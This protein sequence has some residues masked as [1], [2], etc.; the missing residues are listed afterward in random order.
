MYWRVLRL[1]RVRPNGWQRLLLVEGS[2]ASGVVLA[3]ADASSA[4]AIVVLPVTVAAVVKAHDVLAGIL[5]PGAARPGGQTRIGADP[6]G[7]R[8]V[9]Y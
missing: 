3:L 5:D 7:R 4:W 2:V 9:S 6:E 1:Q 8:R